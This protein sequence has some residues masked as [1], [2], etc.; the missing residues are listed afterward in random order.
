MDILEGELGSPQSAVDLLVCRAEG[1]TDEIRKERRKHFREIRER[2]AAARAKR[3][4]TK[5]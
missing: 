3:A 2:R 4:E 1:V 5:K